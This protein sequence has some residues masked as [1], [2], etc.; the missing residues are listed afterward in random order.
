PFQFINIGQHEKSIVLTKMVQR[1]AHNPFNTWQRE[2]IAA[3]NSVAFPTRTLAIVAVDDDAVVRRWLLHK[4]WLA[5]VSYSAFDSASTE[6]VQE[7][8]QITYDNVEIEW[9]SA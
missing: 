7:I 4:A 8:V 9:A 6:L 3:N 5:N 1:D 2:S